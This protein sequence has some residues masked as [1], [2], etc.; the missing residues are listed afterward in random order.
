MLVRNIQLYRISLKVVIS[1]DVI[2]GR[3]SVNIAVFIRDF[4]QA[5][6]GFVYF[7]LAWSL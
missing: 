3:N 5:M 1:V 2:T 7:K 6:I 4:E